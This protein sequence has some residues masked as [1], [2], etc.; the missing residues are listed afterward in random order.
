MEHR[1]RGVPSKWPNV[2]YKVLRLRHL[3][4]TNARGKNK[5]K[6]YIKEKKTAQRRV[7][8]DHLH[9]RSARRPLRHAAKDNVK[10]VKVICLKGYFREILPV[11]AVWTWW[12]CFYLKFKDIFVEN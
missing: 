4:V 12:S 1:N 11:D 10:L 3:N 8:L 9:R 7:D 6:V 5:E 2:L